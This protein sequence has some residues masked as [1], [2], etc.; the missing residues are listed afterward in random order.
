MNRSVS[1]M[2]TNSV[3]RRLLTI[4]VIVLITSMT[5][6][7]Q[8][9]PAH[10]AGTTYYVAPTGNDGNV[11]TLAQPFRTIQHCA[12]VAI[13]GDTCLIRA[14]TYPE[15][16]TPANS[17]TPGNPIIFAPYQNE[18]VTIS[19]LDRIEGWTRHSGNI[20]RAAMP[21]TVYDPA[22]N[23]HSTDQIFVDGQLMNEARWPNISANRQRELLRTNM[24]RATTGRAL[25]DR[26][27]EYTASGLSAF[28]ANFW[29]GA[30][31]NFLPGLTAI[32]TTCDVT[33]NSGSTVNFSCPPNTFASER[34]F[35]TPWEGNRFFLWGK[36]EAL[37]T[38]S[39]WYR[40]DASATLYL[41]APASAD[42]NTRL[43]EA[44]R[45]IW[46]FDL[47]NR[48]HIQING[49][50]ILGASINT[51]ANSRNLVIDEIVA[52]Y[53]WHFINFRAN[54]SANTSGFFY[55]SGKGGI[56]LNGENNVLSNS[57]IRYSAANGVTLRGQNNQVINNIV[58]NSG[59]MAGSEG[60]SGEGPL[61]PA[62]NIISQNTVFNSGRY[63]IGLEPA[64]N[65]LYNDVFSS[66]LQISDLGA[67]YGIN[68][69]GLGADVAY[70]LVHDS[71]AEQNYD[72]DYFGSAGIF[73]DD[74]TYNF[75]VFRNIIWNVNYVGSLFVRG[76]NGQRI[77][78]NRPS[79]DPSGRRII[80]NTVDGPIA[81]NPDQNY[82]PP[83]VMNGTEFRNNTSTSLRLDYP[84][85][86][87]STNIQTDALYLNRSLRDYRLR[88]YSPAIDAG[89]PVPPFTDGF[90]GL[91]PDLGAIEFGKPTFVAGA[92]LRQRDL[93]TL[94][95][96]CNANQSLGTANCSL[97]NLPYAR[98]LPA[99]FQVRVGNGTPSQNCQ[100]N[101]NYKT[102]V[103]S[104]R[105]TNIPLDGQVG[106][107]PI[108]IRIGTGSWLNTG[109]TVDIGP[110][111]INSLSP[112]SGP[113]S[114]NTRIAIRG[115]NFD[116]SLVRYVVPVSLSNTTGQTLYNYQVAL[117]LNTASLIA[118]RKL[119]SDCSLGFS[120]KYGDLDHW[121]QGTCNTSATVV[122]VE[123]PYLPPGT[124][125]VSLTYSV[126]QLSNRTS[127][128]RTFPY[129]D[130]FNDGVLSTTW[131]LRN[132]ST[133]S[134]TETGST[135]R[136]AGTADASTQN[137]TVGFTA[138]RRA[139]G[140]PQSNFAIDASIQIVASPPNNLHKINVGG[141]DSLNFIF[142]AG[143]GD[144]RVG[145]WNGQQ[146][147]QNG[148][149][150]L[151]G[152][153]FAPQTVSFAFTPDGSIRYYENLL[154]RAIR[155]GFTTTPE[156]GRFD[157]RP[158][159]PGSIDVRFDNIRIRQFVFPEPTATLGSEQYQGIRVTVGGLTCTDIVVTSSTSLNCLTPAHPAGPA[160][161]VITNPDGVSA[162]QTG[163]FTYQ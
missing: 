91:Q 13:A 82:T 2:P 124:S 65:I 98:K 95:V 62:T 24:A 12:T 155:T 43:V 85:V 144:R 42:P 59:Y 34:N 73:L 56:I 76:T 114:G 156:W 143:P 157:Y 53:I 115:R 4:L 58:Q 88:D 162:T 102:V 41:W 117:T 111:A 139:L 112:T 25:N 44:K 130:T 126:N 103:G 21:W 64:T 70:N 146:R 78:P 84:G 20:W 158:G 159:K 137:S 149:S 132:S 104:G 66:H 119:R 63:L 6:S 113:T 100:T 17:G 147:V 135:I 106:R 128:S 138:D 54:G 160:D 161:V 35:Y 38:G 22:D 48:E 47:R 97:T 163:G 9:T 57:L 145:F 75:D 136:I 153:T 108:S 125:T 72:L 99:D 3:Y 142:T 40:D 74:D 16:V 151:D 32:A 29:Q 39:E 28:P 101:M 86:I 89:V 5:P 90:S 51:N 31:I 36:Y 67:I 120:D 18:S 77:V 107:L 37:N 46:A 118:Q 134:V 11:G 33:G 133:F 7:L 94:T 152:D 61:L 105:C 55:M 19:G 68:E 92:T 93:A 141:A 81:A 30:K 131:T 60:I 148:D 80:N 150:I 116:P 52:S 123:V 87:S 110:L 50:N 10:A 49:L 121:V 1:A 140:S 79:G 45:R 27:G 69:D 26:D 122:W 109:R 127:T 83:Q 15:T 8:T 71:N 154:L 129:F 23:P 14:G 96:G